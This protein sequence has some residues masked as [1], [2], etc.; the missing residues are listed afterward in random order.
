[1]PDD[2][3]ANASAST[4]DRGQAIDKMPPPR[5]DGGTIPGRN[6][7]GK[8]QSDTGRTDQTDAKAETAADAANRDFDPDE[9]QS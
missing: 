7:D 5:D 8:G 1:M 2:Q 4:D 9:E 6:D 3:H